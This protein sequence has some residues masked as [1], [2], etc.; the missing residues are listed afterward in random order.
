M[1]FAHSI[2][3][4]VV[5]TPSIGNAD[6]IHTNMTWSERNDL[7]LDMSIRNKMSEPDM[8]PHWIKSMM[9]EHPDKKPF[10]CRIR[11]AA[12][13]ARCCRPVLRSPCTLCVPKLKLSPRA[14]LVLKVRLLF[15]REHII[16]H[17][18]GWP[19]TDLSKKLVHIVRG[20]IAS[21]ISMTCSLLL[22][23]V[24]L[25]SKWHVHSQVVQL[26]GGQLMPSHDI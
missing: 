11:P 9:K 26:H 7:I 15:F 13:A 12:C 17:P 25:S 19:P 24:F 23:S 14:H 16:L 8:A 5:N 21:S 3:R 6:C 18:N 1:S 2:F 4:D 20:V 10:E 22:H